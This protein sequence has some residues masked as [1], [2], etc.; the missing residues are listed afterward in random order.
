MPLIES[1]NTTRSGGGVSPGRRRLVDRWDLAMPMLA[2]IITVLGF[3]PFARIE[4]DG[5]HDGVMLKPAMDVRSGQVLFRDSMTIYGP[6]NTYLHA[7]FLSLL[8]PKL[9]SLKVGTVVM[10][11]LAAGFLAAAWGRLLPP[12][13][14]ALSLIL[15]WSLAHFYDGSTMYPWSSVNALPFQA[16]ALYFLLKSTPAAGVRPLSC[17]LLCGAS[18]G[19]CYWC[20]FTVGLPLIAALG[21]SYVILAYASGERPWTSRR[22]YAF[23]AGNVAVHLAFLA[24]IVFTGSTTDWIYQNYTW[25]SRHFVR[26]T[27]S[28]LGNLLRCMLIPPAFRFSFWSGA[29]RA[30]LPLIIVLMSIAVLAFGFTAT[31]QAGAAEAGTGRGEVP[32]RWRSVAPAVTLMVLGLIALVVVLCQPPLESQ[33]RS[34]PRESWYFTIP[35][36][37]LAATAAI[38]TRCLFL[39]ARGVEPCVPAPIVSGYFASLVALASWPQC[40]PQGDNVHGWWALAPGIGVFVFWMLWLA[41]NRAL[42]VTLALSVLVLPLV[43]QRATQAVRTLLVPRVTVRDPTVLAGMRL[44]PKDAA[45]L[46]PFLAALDDYIAKHPKSALLIDGADAI[47]YATFVPDLHNPSNIWFYDRS[48]PVPRPEEVESRRHEFIRDRRPLV[49]FAWK[50]PNPPGQWTPRESEAY[51]KRVR[52]NLD[53]KA[54]MERIIH[55]DRYE[56]LAVTHV[57]NGHETLVLLGPRD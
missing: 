54:N 19:L 46:S 52:V 49:V 55:D 42:A 4:I 23:V 18:A 15:W 31:L 5:C 39:R 27:P 50:I 24:V 7:G 45:A 11:G 17:P 34:A 48:V 29:V 30:L 25:H 10:Y 57:A 53:R 12:P 41:G 8:G 43:L 13:L 16:A 37:I 28:A 32:S 22:L 20:R 33:Y 14:T 36:S 44:L 56:Q 47:I 26:S 3:A 9:L 51:H 6:L 1:P 40:F 21:A 2:S 35:Y 38:T